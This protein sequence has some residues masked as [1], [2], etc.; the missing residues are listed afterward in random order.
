MLERGSID[1]GEVGGI[2]CARMSTSHDFRHF[3]AALSLANLAIF[4]FETEPTCVGAP[5]LLLVAL[6]LCDHTLEDYL[7]LVRTL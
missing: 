2:F 3:F 1:D 4:D 5:L 6:E 7:L